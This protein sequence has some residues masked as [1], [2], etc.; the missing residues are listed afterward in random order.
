VPG[1]AKAGARDGVTMGVESSRA[2][3]P[4]LVHRAALG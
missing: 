4:N 3:G 2:A 1:L